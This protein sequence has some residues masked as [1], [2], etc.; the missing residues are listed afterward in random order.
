LCGVNPDTVSQWVSRGYLTHD[1]ERR[2]LPVAVRYRGRI[3]LDPVE[4]AKAKHATD[5]RARRAA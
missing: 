1:G 2:K 4:V 5:K 3:M